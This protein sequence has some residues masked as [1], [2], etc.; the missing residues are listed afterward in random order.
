MTPQS[1]KSLQSRLGRFSEDL[2]EPM[3]R[4]ERRHR[5]QVCVEGLWLDGEHKS[6]APMVARLP[7]ADMQALRQSVGQS[8]WEVKQVQR[9][10]AH[11]VVDL[12]RNAQVWNL[13]DISQDRRAFGGGGTVASWHLEESSQLPRGGR[14]ALV[15]QGS[16][17]SAVVVAQYAARPSLTCPRFLVQS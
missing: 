9:R 11:T 1:P 6:I 10:L 16:E 5:A 2:F 12:L 7:G 4:A 13:D 17:L 15:E 8:P 3:G 14:P